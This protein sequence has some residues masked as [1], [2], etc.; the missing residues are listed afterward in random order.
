[1]IVYNW[2]MFV[3]LNVDELGLGKRK[4]E[5]Y[6]VGPQETFDTV[7]ELVAT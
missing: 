5:S 2:G 1:L 7:V 6:N 3:Q 4:T